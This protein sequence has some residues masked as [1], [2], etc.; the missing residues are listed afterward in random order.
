MR[1]SHNIAALWLKMNTS[2]GGLSQISASCAHGKQ[3][4]SLESAAVRDSDDS[5]V[6]SL[7][8]GARS[9]LDFIWT[10]LDY[11]HIPTSF[12]SLAGMKI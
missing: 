8:Q 4:L 6:V 9:S 3:K 2:W 11:T 10:P 7:Q 12:L 5:A 1:S